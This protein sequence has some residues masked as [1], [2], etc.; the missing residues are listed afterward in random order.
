MLEG[1]RTTHHN[2]LKLF[3]FA[4]VI[5]ATYAFFLDWSLLLYAYHIAA[6]AVIGRGIT[7]P[8][9]FRFD[10]VPLPSNFNVRK[11]VAKAVV[12]FLL[13]PALAHFYLYDTPYWV[14]PSSWLCAIAAKLGAIVLAHDA[15][16]VPP[17][18][19]LTDAALESSALYARVATSSV[20]P[21][22]FAVDRA[23]LLWLLSVDLL[24]CVLA[25]C[26][27]S[28][29]CTDHAFALTSSWSSSSASAAAGS[30]DRRCDGWFSDTSEGDDGQS[31]SDIDRARDTGTPS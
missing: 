3:Q 16:A 9:D 2:L 11:R 25:F 6:A 26:M 24:K 28:V 15:A 14:A 13:P 19:H 21:V 18:S 22:T 4:F 7:D 23:G 27:L 8:H 17:S 1:Q 10:V 31:G 30:A 29:D 5:E 20:V 12:F